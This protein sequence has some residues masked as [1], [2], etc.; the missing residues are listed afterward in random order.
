MIVL[1]SRLG[2]YIPTKVSVLVSMYVV[3]GVLGIPYPCC[4]FPA[5]LQSTGH[6]FGGSDLH[7][8]P[9]Q[10]LTGKDLTCSA[11]LT[12]QPVYNIQPYVHLRT[13]R[14]LLVCKCR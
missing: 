4:W 2:I 10:P 8:D 12:K 5:Q 11:L 14:Y 13:Y 3:L 9:R 1:G 7:L 6:S